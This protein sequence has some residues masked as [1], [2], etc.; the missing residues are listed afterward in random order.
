M[1]LSGILCLRVLGIHA[2]V[3]GDAITLP[4]ASSYEIIQERGG[5][6]SAARN[7]ERRPQYYRVEMGFLQ[8]ENRPAPVGRTSFGEMRC[9]HKMQISDTD[10]YLK[11]AIEVQ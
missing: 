10:D 11:T 3:N 6:E 4:D 1:Q 8:L 7:A 2:D 9:T 5:N